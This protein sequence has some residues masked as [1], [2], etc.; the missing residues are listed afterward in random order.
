ML[1]NNLIQSN[2]F[3][4]FPAYTLDGSDF[5]KDNKTNQKADITDKPD[6]IEI[7]QGNNNKSKKIKKIVFG[8]TLA[9]TIIGAGVVGL[10]FAKGFHGSSLKK[11]SKFTERITKELQESSTSPKKLSKKALYYSR[12]G[13]KKTVDTMQASSNFTAMK[14]WITDKI[15]ETNRV[16]AK[17]ARGSRNLFKKVVNRTLGKQYDKVEVKVKDLTSLLKHYNIEDLSNLNPQDAMQKVTIKGKTLTLGEW[18]QRLSKQ[19]QRLESNFDN[20]FSLGARRARDTKRSQLLAGLSDKVGE[21]FFKNKSTLLN[22]ENYKTYATEDLSQAAYSELKEEIIKA[23]RHVS[24]NITTIHDEIKTS[25]T[26]FS[27]SVKPEDEVTTQAVQLLKKQ[28][29]KFKNCSGNNEAK[30]REKISKELTS[31]V[32]DLI[33]TM[34]KNKNYSAL[35]QEEMVKYLSSIKQTV[36]SSGAGSKGSLEEIMTILNGLNQT[37]LKSSGKK[38]ISDSNLKEFGKLSKQISKGLE[39]ATEMEAEEYFLKRA[40][41]EVGSAATDVLSV[42]FPVGVGAYAVAKGDDKDEK[43]SATLTTCIPLVGTF[44]TFVYGTTKMF[45]GAKNLAFSL[46]SGAV[47]GKM[48]N[49]LDK[50]YKKY[51]D[52]GSVVNVI[53]D[54]GGNFVNGMTPHYIQDKESK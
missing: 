26:S 43:I 7:N 12:K 1:N 15:L 32:D 13:A 14:D 20:S 16:T 46:V 8:S 40:E 25:L 4:Q 27:Q 31:V 34:Q 22:P 47:L 45:A 19:T 6:V 29:E 37:S 48:G 42:L 33:K 41:L 53:M 2:I 38:I 11:L 50:L 44:A 10:F 35:E 24:N 5:V 18:I 17:F 39:K 28:L 52:S 23:K 54:E 51:K 30:A 36:L 3:N 21:R 49:Y 9:T